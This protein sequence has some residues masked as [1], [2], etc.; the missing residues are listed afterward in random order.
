MDTNVR[1]YTYVEPLKKQMIQGC[2]GYWD[3]EDTEIQRGYRDTE[4]IPG[5]RGYSDS[6]DTDI[7][8]YM[9]IESYKVCSDTD[10]L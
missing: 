2:R 7:Q 1:T 6:E 5:Y 8:G 9:G 3:K 10:M 4:G